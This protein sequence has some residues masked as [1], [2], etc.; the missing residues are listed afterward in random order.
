MPSVLGRGLPPGAGER[1]Q[2]CGLDDAEPGRSRTGWRL[3]PACPLGVSSAAWTEGDHPEAEHSIRDVTWPTQVGKSAES[4]SPL[5]CRTWL[6]GTRAGAGQGRFLGGGRCHPVETLRSTPRGQ[7]RGLQPESREGRRG[8]AWG[9]SLS[10]TH[11]RCLPSLGPP[12]PRARRAA[13]PAAPGAVPGAP[14]SVVP[15]SVPQ[16][17]RNYGVCSISHIVKRGRFWS[18]QNTCSELISAQ[19][20]TF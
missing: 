18:E 3:P 5:V 6:E 15:T 1:C 16:R 2:A 13:A 4:R 9:T 20:C 17:N 7:W 12:H 19:L 8:S 10:H 11:S 14:V